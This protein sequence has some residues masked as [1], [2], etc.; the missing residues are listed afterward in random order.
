VH[1]VKA[2]AAYEQFT[3]RNDYLQARRQDFVSTAV[4]E[5]F[6]GDSNSQT[7]NGTA[8]ERARVNFFGRVDYDYAGKYIFQFNWRYDG[9]ENFPKENRFG[10]FPGVSVGWR[11]SEEAFWKENISWMDYFKLRASWG[12][13]GNDAVDAFQ[14]ITAYTFNNPGIFG[15]GINTGVWLQ[16][17]ANPNITWEVANTFNVGLE[18]KFLKYWSFDL[19]LFYTKRTN[20][21][22]TRNAAVPQYAGLSLP[23]E[24]IG[25][26]SNRGVEFSLGYNRRFGSDWGFMASGNFSYNRSRIDYIDEPATTLEWQKRTGL[27]INN[28][29]LM[30]E[31]SGIFRTQQEL[32]SYP[33]LSNVRLGDVRFVDTDGNGIINGDDRIRPDKS[34]VPRINFGINL[35]LT[36]R[37]WS[38]TALFQGAADVS[39]Y[40][41]MEAGAIGNFTKDFFDN[42]WTPE[43]PNAKYPRTYDRISTVTGGGSYINTFFLNDA[44]Y[45]RMKSIELGY[46]LPKSLIQ[47]TFLENVRFSLSGYNLLT[48]TGFK[49]LDPETLVDGQWF[50]GWNTPQSKVINFGVNVTF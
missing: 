4:D 42:R 10:F 1:N 11:A 35:G 45:L 33:H 27:P 37:D 5:L 14:Y 22:A 23:M 15:N 12:Q 29:G 40:T 26:M 6:A 48:F 18:T 25:E 16:R 21:L 19:D 32:D 8:I 41:F 34:F 50:S 43:T 31:S 24:N 3:Y 28:V 44:S 36:W 46:S 30:Y 9:S 39:Q 2:F 13:M 49:N 17:T 7:N 20:V 47:S 38:L